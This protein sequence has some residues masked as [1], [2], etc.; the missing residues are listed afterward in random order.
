MELFETSDPRDRM[1]AMYNIAAGIENG[2]RQDFPK[3]D[4]K[5]P[6]T[7]TCTNLTKYIIQTDQTLWFLASAGTSRHK[8]DGLP[9]WV[10]DWTKAA[11]TELSPNT[12]QHA[13]YKAAGESTA[14]LVCVDDDDKDGKAVLATSSFRCM[15]VATVGG[16]IRTPSPESAAGFVQQ[17]SEIAANTGS[18]Y[19]EGQDA[20]TAFAR[21]LV[22]DC[23]HMWTQYPVD[24]DYLLC[25]AVVIV[26]IVM[27]GSSETLARTDNVILDILHDRASEA[28]RRSMITNSLHN[29]VY[30]QFVMNVAHRCFFVTECG[31]FGL[32]P[33]QTQA[34]DE[35]HIISGG[36]V[37][38]VL[39]RSANGAV[40]GAEAHHT[41]LGT[42]YVHGIMDGETLCRDDFEWD[43]LLIV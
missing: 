7:T 9:S 19:P 2:R 30:Q 41:L 37:P 13:P 35:I 29:E 15:R 10:V 17:W 34:G 11:D 20:A 24:E 16:P 28:A 31:H 18:I 25:V 8:L 36:N 43:E 3:A 33:V 22:G 38:F 1:F 12:T 39:R 23:R 26:I 40:T 27:T 21:T 4:Y 32:G 6:I 42:A 14:I 5:E